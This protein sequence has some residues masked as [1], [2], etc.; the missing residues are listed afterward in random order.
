MRLRQKLL[1][2]AI[3]VLAATL[4]PAALA[5]SAA[6]ADFQQFCLSTNAE[7]IAALNAADAATGWKRDDTNAKS[8]KSLAGGSDGRVFAPG[9][10]NFRLLA[11]GEQRSQYAT[12]SITGVRTIRQCAVLAVEPFDAVAAELTKL[13][14]L[15]PGANTNDQKQWRYA[16][17]DGEHLSLDNGSVEDA[18]RAGQGKEGTR[19]LL[20]LRIDG[21]VILR[22]TTDKSEAMPK[23]SH[24]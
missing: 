15:K 17:V 4:S 18:V 10:A 14:P 11:V 24:E 23:P 22:L 19:L 7:P 5:Q 12:R 6:L 9:T 20:A 8:Y 1:A 13:I 3:P 21:G 16:V 2:F